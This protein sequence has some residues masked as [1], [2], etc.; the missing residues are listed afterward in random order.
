M[1]EVAEADAIEDILAAGQVFHQYLG[2]EVAL[3]QRCDRRQLARIL[4]RFGGCDL[5]QHLRRPVGARPDHAAVDTD[6]AGLHAVGD[7]RA[8]G[9]AA[10][11]RHRNR[12]DAGGSRG[13]QKAAASQSRERFATKIVARQSDRHCMPP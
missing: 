8:V 13:R 10:E 3:G 5:D 4:E 6:V 11:I 12:A 2:G 1:R 7:L 9:G